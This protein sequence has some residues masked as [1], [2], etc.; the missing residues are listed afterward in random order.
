[1][2]HFIISKVRNKTNKRSIEDIE[3]F[4]LKLFTELG[5]P[6]ESLAKE[7][8]VFFWWFERQSNVPMESYDQPQKT[9]VIY[10]S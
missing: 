8:S 7:F 3:S 4:F 1:M 2:K 10:D 6:R 9:L 5:D